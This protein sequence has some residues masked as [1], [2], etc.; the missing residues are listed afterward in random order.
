MHQY[1]NECI[2]YNRD[3]MDAINRADLAEKST[4]FFFKIQIRYKLSL[5]LGIFYFIFII[6]K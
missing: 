5:L 6:L 4:L 2:R 3:T 1:R